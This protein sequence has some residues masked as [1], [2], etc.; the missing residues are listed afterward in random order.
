ME[1]CWKGKFDSRDAKLHYCH[2]K[3]NL[4]VGVVKCEPAKDN[5]PNEILWK[6]DLTQHKTVL[7]FCCSSLV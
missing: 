1:A 2:Q 7:I 6:G 5:F 4:G 3:A